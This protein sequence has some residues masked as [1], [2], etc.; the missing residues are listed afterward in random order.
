MRASVFTLA[1]CALGACSQGSAVTTDGGTEASTDA[2]V[3]QLVQ[4]TVDPHAAPDLARGPSV[5]G[6]GIAFRPNFSNRRSEPIACG[7][8]CRRVIEGWVTQHEVN[9]IC[10][11]GDHLWSY[12]ITGIHR[13]NL[14]TGV[15]D[16]YLAIDSRGEPVRGY[17]TGIA[18]T[19]EAVYV[20][21]NEWV[22][23]NGYAESIGVFNETRMATTTIWSLERPLQHT[24]FV[25]MMAREDTLVFSA[26]GFGLAIKSGL[27][28][29]IEWV[30]DAFGEGGTYFL[31]D[32][33]TLLT[34]EERGFAVVSPLRSLRERLVLPRGERPFAGYPTG[35]EDYLAFHQAPEATLG[36][37]RSRMALY[38]RRTGV[39]RG[40]STSTSAQ[41]RLSPYVEGDWVVWIEVD[42]VQRQ[43]NAEIPSRSLW[44]H[45]ISTGQTTRLLANQVMRLPM[46]MDGK[47]YFQVETLSQAPGGGGWQ[48]NGLYVTELPQ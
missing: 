6:G 4:P 45:R 10:R 19:R 35:N 22:E 31:A 47:V 15:V 44:A 8:S 39:L 24:G 13:G 17:F 7:A 5:L 12:S 25:A 3:A 48:L 11:R 14:R 21:F 43:G 30:A 40:I 46:L 33:S 28:R 26:L 18:C 41:E 42:G 37:V 36:V 23:E 38:N 1:L 32:T 20:G 2:G 29:P 34:S 27:H 9:Q 16:R